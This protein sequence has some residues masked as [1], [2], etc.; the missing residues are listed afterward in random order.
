MSEVPQRHDGEATTVFLARVLAGEGAP[1]W[2]V[3]LARDGH[4][5]DFKSP[6]AMPE[7]QLHTDARS[8]GLPQV[9]AWVEQGVFDSTKEES[10]AWAQS[11]EGQEVFR[12]LVGGMKK[13]RAQRRADEKRRRG[14]DR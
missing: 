11:P 4:Y 2:M 10:T 12:E 13:N 1:E 9:A 8:N 3:S 6:L 7:T 14:G 5:D